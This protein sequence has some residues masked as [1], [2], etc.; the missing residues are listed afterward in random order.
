MELASMERCSNPTDMSSPTAIYTPQNC[1]FSCPLQWGLTVFWKQP[2]PDDSWFSEL[3][4]LTE[5][6]GIR[7]FSHRFK[8]QDISQFSISSLPH[9]SPLLIVQ[10]V[11]GRLQHLIRKIQP[12][13][14]KRNFA[15]RS[16]GKVTRNDVEGYVSTQLDHHR[17][18][19]KVV[20]QRLAGVQIRNDEIKLSMQRRT[21]HGAYWYNLHLV[22]VHRDRSPVIKEEILQR[23][24]S[25]ILETC[26][27]KEL[28]LSR[29]GILADHIHVVLGC[30]FKHSPED[31]A[32]SFLNSL[33]SAHG[34]RTVY[35]FG[36]FIGTVGEYTNKAF[37]SDG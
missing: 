30:C 24:H 9:V 37:E 3:S 34:L 19:D 10:R 11:K 32:L 1:K 21:S 14:F 31:I 15:I 29:A 33:A 23:V 4:A 35:Q 2:P 27:S 25:T 18:A 26:G 22:F 20:Q 16:V 8:E 12:A 5:S 6:D 36:G 28:L 17:M 7:L 13:P